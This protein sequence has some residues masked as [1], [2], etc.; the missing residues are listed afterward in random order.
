MAKTRTAGDL[1]HRV[2]FDRRID[3]NDGNDDGNTQGE[4]QEQFQCRAGFIHLRGGESIMADRLQGV[5]PQ[6]IFVRASSQS[7]AVTT[8]WRIRDAR[9]DIEFNIR[10]ISM[11]DDRQ[12]LDFLCQSGGADG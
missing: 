3:T 5:H 12:W 6:V 11:S 4:W 7:K 10:D 2:A 8:E 1:F 9:T